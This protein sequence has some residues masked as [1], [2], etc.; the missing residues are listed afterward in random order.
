MKSKHIYTLAKTALTREEII[1]CMEKAID[2]LDPESRK[3]ITGMTT[4]LSLS[5]R[6]VGYSSAM[7]LLMKIGIAEMEADYRNRRQL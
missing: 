6:S 4:A 1:E 2:K 7:E 5:L 3:A